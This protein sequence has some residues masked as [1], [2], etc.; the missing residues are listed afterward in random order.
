FDTG[1]SLILWQISCIGDLTF[2]L[3]PYDSR[4]LHVLTEY[5]CQ[6]YDA[7]HPV[8]IYEAAEYPIFD[9]TIERVPL[10]KLPEAQISLISTLYIPPQTEAPLDYE[11]LDRLGIDFHLLTPA[12][13]PIDIPA[14]SRTTPTTP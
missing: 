1:C 11:M 10:A 6:Y 5:L 13:Q 8:I 7:A 12:P 2:N 3:G 9:P 14:G 4:G